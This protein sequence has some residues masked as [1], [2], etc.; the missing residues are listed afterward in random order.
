[1]RNK[2][3]EIEAYVLVATF[4]YL[5]HFSYFFLIVIYSKLAE[6]SLKDRITFHA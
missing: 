5:S 4:Q 1:M 2:H 6:E 3:D